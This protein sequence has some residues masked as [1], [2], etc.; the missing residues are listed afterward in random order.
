MSA[1]KGSIAEALLSFLFP[2]HCPHCHAYVEKRGDWCPECLA[3]TAQFTLYPGFGSVARAC[4]F[5]AYRGGLRDLIRGLKYQRKESVLP[6]IGTVL[7]F[8]SEGGQRAMLEDFLR[9]GILAVPV[10]LA[11]KRRKERGFNQ[12]ERIF[13]EWLAENGI[14]MRH[15]LMRTRETRPM[16][17]LGR[18]A[19]RENL[20]GAFALAD[21]VTAE[22]IRG[23][24]ILLLDDI[25]TTGAT[26]DACASVLR[27]AGASEV[28]GM[29]LAS[30]HA[31]DHR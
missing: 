14:E 4:S 1:G 31:S 13:A 10:P 25:L 12:T 23:R 3:E 22:E 16:Y 5:G 28:L 9:P 29:V 6:Y 18:S 11:E 17:G 15:V 26:L 21:G 7:H 20:R 19:R 2:P 27:R 30:D 24:R 8:V